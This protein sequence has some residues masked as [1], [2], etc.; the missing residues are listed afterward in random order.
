MDVKYGD[1]IKED[2]KIIVDTC[3]Y[4]NV[5]EQFEYNEKYEFI[6]INICE[7]DKDNKNNN[8][9]KIVKVAKIHI[10]FYPVNQIFKTHLE[11]IDYR[12][13]SPIL[14]YTTSGNFYNNI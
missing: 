14:N 6:E 10:P 8:S 1:Q 7:D 5:Y 4:L 12:K 2:I 11:L 3:I 13:D 9:K